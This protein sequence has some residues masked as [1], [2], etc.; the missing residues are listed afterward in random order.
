MLEQGLMLLGGLI[1]IYLGGRWLVEGASQLAAIL[2]VRPMI[3]GLTIMGFGT[4]S[5]ELALGLLANAE[6]LG[7]VSLGNIIGSN[8]GNVTF[9]IAASAIIMTVVV[10]FDIIRK[11]GLAAV[12]GVLML[13]AFSLLGG[14]EWWGGFLMLT[15]FAVYLFLLLRGLERCHPSKDVTCQ[16]EDMEAKKG[17]RGRGIILILIGL[18]L[19]LLGAQIA[20][21]GAEGLARELGITEV[22][23]GITLVSFGTTLPEFTVAVLSALRKRP[24]LAVG[25]LLGTITFNTLVVLGAGAVVS[26]RIDVPY[27]VLITGVLP[28]ITFMGLTILIIY[29]KNAIGRKAGMALIALYLVYLAMLI[30]YQ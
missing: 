18:F 5:P 22:L 8:I 30:A 25:N 1:S 24:D 9:V 20:I 7:S 16:F 11:E 23:I 12:T 26:G 10:E 27:S 21:D 2:G 19:L 13:F 3:I 17:G 6:G 14:I 28:M 4:S 15:A 29:T